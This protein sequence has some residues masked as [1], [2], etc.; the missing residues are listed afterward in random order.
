[1]NEIKSLLLNS[2]YLVEKKIMPTIL[3]QV[4]HAAIEAK[5][6]GEQTGKLFDDDA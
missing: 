2:S 3:V 6:L 1:M 5:A 4:T